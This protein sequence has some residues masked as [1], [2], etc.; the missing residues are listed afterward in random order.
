MLDCLIL[1]HRNGKFLHKTI[2]PTSYGIKDHQ[3]KMIDFE[4]STRFQND[5]GVHFQQEDCEFKGDVVTGSIAAMEGKNHS[6][7]DDLESLI[8]TLMIFFDQ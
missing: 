8:Y 5:A 2:K 1:L 6:R 4:H 7:R 3:L